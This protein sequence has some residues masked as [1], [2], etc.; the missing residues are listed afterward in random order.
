M[1]SLELS[2]SLFTQI[3]KQNKLKVS[4]YPVPLHVASTVSRFLTFPRSVSKTMCSHSLVPRPFPPPVFDRL[5]YASPSVFAYC[6]RSNTGGGNGLGTRLVQPCIELLEQGC[7]AYSDLTHE[8]SGV[9]DCDRH[10]CRHCQSHALMKLWTALYLRWGDHGYLE[11]T[12]L[13]DIYC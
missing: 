11:M 2:G 13:H 4:L 1:R 3:C 12:L 8:N 7:T 9:W 6:K 5:Q 10:L